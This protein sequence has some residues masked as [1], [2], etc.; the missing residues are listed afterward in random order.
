MSYATEKLCVREGD[1]LFLLP[2]LNDNFFCQLKP[3]ILKK[4]PE[5]WFSNELATLGSHKN[6]M[7][8]VLETFIF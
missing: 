1:P 4:E 8:P 5:W 7:G 6:E 3:A 2:R